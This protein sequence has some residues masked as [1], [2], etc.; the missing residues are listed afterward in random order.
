NIAAAR[1]YL[2]AATKY[3][4]RTSAVS[5]VALMQVLGFVV[6]PALQAAVTPLGDET[7]ILMGLPMNM[8]TAAGW[9]NA[10]LGILNF[11]F[12]LPCCFTERNIAAKEAMRDQ[13]KQSEEETWKSVRTD[14]LAAWS[15]ICAFFVL[16]FNFVLLETL[17]TS[18]TMDQ[19]AWGREDS[20]FYMGLLMSVG[21]VISCVVF[22]GVGPLSK[23]FDERRVMLWGGFFCM[24][25][26]R[27]IHIPWGT[28]P[29][30]IA[31]LGAYGNE[32]TDPLTNATKLGCPSVQEWCRY[33]PRMTILQFVI[34]YG[35]TAIGYPIGV[36]LVQSIFT[37]VLGTRPQGV[38][39][40]LLT[41]GG[42][43]SRVLGPVF[44]GLIYT[45]Y[46]IYHTFGVTGLTLVVS[47]V[48]LSLVYDR[49]VSPDK[50]PEESP[51]KQPEEVPLEQLE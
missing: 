19:F 26:G 48:W 17:G 14:Y 18:L 44:V 43:A 23:R 13:G 9:I 38:W 37:K 6:G 28:E 51:K 46:G 8:Y 3:K 29:P 47:M 15:V 12:F 40:G 20:V 1:S 49:L 24:I 27:I 11:V 36:S 25:I 33:T 31:E 4:E 50:R 22:S 10:L 42:C 34:G 7:R 30:L 45:R 5:M 41:G 21:A 16:V 2:S 32:T 39:Q 35:F